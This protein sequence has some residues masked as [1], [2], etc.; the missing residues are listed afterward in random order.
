MKAWDKVLLARLSERPTADYYIHNIFEEFTEMH[1]DRYF[2]DD[3]SIITGIGLLNGTPVTIIGEE[4][5]KGT[6]DKIYRN[7]GMPNPEGYRKALRAMKQ[8]EKFNRPI[9]TFIDTP[10]AY[11]GIGAE[12]RGQGEAIA[13][14]L[15]SMSSLKVPIIC[16]VIGEG[17]SGGGLAIGVGDVI[18]MLENSIYS[19]LS[20]EGFAT[21][22]W[23]DSTKAEEAAEIMKITAEDLKK[24]GIIDKIIKEPDGGAHNDPEKMSDDIKKMIIK[25]LKNFSQYTEKELTQKRYNKYRGI[26]MY[27]IEGEST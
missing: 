10:G 23:K 1:G 8:A 2:S 27:R 17:S 14:N 20:P 13:R 19:V 25:E 12:E 18:I 24:L 9:I 26:G 22:L 3:K 15:S 11:P 6:K 16:I 4:K 7:F 5:G 21:I